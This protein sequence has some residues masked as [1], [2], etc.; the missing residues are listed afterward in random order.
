MAAPRQTRLTNG[1]MSILFEPIQ[2]GD[3]QLDM[4]VRCYCKGFPQ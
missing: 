4:A 2:L 1:V 3:L